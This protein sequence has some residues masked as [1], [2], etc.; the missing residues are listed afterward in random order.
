M[1]DISGFGKRLREERVRNGMNQSELARAIGFTRAAV[2]KWERDSSTDASALGV[3]LAATELKTTVNYLLTGK[4]KEV[5]E[6][7]RYSP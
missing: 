4:K 1:R 7:D 5:E 6:D 2:S 3:C